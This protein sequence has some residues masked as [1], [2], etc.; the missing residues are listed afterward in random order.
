[1]PPVTT[2][3]AHGKGHPH[4]HPAHKTHHRPKSHYDTSVIQ[5]IINIG[6]SPGLSDDHI[7][8][9][10]MVGIQESGLRNLDHGDGS[11][12]GWRQ[13]VRKYYGTVANRRNVP[14]SVTRFYEELERVPRGQRTLGHWGQAVQPSAYPDAYDRH[15]AEAQRILRLYGGTGATGAALP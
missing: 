15:L 11:S 2:P 3:K 9:A 1:M 13:E 5:N 14:A 12:V 6:R 8:T 4:D 10:L 7:V